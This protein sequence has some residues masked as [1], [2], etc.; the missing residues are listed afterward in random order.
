[1]HISSCIVVEKIILQRATN[2]LTSLPAEPL[3]GFNGPTSQG[4]EEKREQ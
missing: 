3:D 1:M 2:V 4:R